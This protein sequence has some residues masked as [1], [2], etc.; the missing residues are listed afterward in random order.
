MSDPV[1][2]PLP[3]RGRASLWLAAPT[4]FAGL[5]TAG[6]RLAAAFL[7]LLLALAFTALAVPDPTVSAAQPTNDVSDLGIYESVIAGL[8]GGGDY[9]ALL[10]DAL[11]SGGY[12]L[13]PFVTFRLPG[14]SVVQAILPQ[15]VTIAILYLLAAGVVVAWWLRLRSLLS[16]PLTRS[17]L[18][19][20]LAGGL[21]PFV[22]TD[23][24]A[25]HEIWA[26]M[27]VA[28]SLAIWRPDRWLPSVALALVAMLVRETAALLPMVMAAYALKAGARREALGWALALL[29][30]ALALV[31]HAWAVA[32]VVEPLD[33]TSPG[34]SGLHGPGFFVRS[35]VISTA[36][37]A[38][39]LALAAPLVALSLFGWSAWRDPVG[40]RTAT[41]FFGY[42]AVIAIF[43]RTN[44]FYWALMPA[45]VFLIGLMFVPDAV[46]DIATRLLDRRRVRVQRI[47]Q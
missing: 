9:Y 39:P 22:Q 27:L 44:T 20:V 24:I 16:R 6:A 2:P 5:N 14:H 38:L 8:R 43:A 37:S 45:P 4:R 1:A 42:A 34:W 23:L 12:P 26:A 33:P 30:F 25:F 7:A 11:R 21:V 18:A 35:L 40:A 10:A 46:R 41:L 32:Q 17:I 19:L 15:G 28:L 47:T 36:L 29:A 13:R 31:A 3:Q